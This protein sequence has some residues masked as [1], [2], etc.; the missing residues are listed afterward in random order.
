LRAKA[1]ADDKGNAAY[2]G[3]RL[4]YTSAVSARGLGRGVGARPGARCRRAA[5]L[6]S[7]RPGRRWQAPGRRPG[8]VAGTAGTGT[9][10]GVVSDRGVVGLPAARSALADTRA[11]AGGGARGQPAPG[12]GPGRRGRSTSRI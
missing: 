9:G 12:G 2:C 11:A 6:A 8:A 4:R 3:V 10:P 7:A 1:T 5:L